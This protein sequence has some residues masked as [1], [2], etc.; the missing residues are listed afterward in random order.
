[1]AWVI[2]GLVAL[3]LCG[4]LVAVPIHFGAGAAPLAVAMVAIAIAL[5]GWQLRDLWRGEARA[6]LGIGTAV[7]L[8][9][10]G[11]GVVAP[12]IDALW[13]S[14]SA[15]ALVNDRNRTLRPVV[16]AGYAE[17][18]VVF[19]LGT[20]TK[21]STASEAATIVSKLPDT[22][23]L[24]SNREDAVFRAVL[25]QKGISVDSLGEVSGLNYSNGRAVTLTLYETAR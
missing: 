19:L 24:V 4:A 25:G 13:V 2:W 8:W 14:R 10:A 9:A 12:R 15:T 3:A 22:L 1:V 21:L 5:A 18:S 23:V 6:W 20:A 16:V 7:A 11:F 17:P